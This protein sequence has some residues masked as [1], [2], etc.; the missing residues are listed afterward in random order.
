LNGWLAGEFDRV[1][2]ASFWDY[3]L[4]FV[5]IGAFSELALSIAGYDIRGIKKKEFVGIVRWILGSALVIGLIFLGVFIG[6]SLGASPLSIVL[7][8]TIFFTVTASTDT[9]SALSRTWFDGLVSN[10]ILVSVLIT[11]GFW[12][13]LLLIVAYYPITVI[14]MIL[15]RKAGQFSYGNGD[16]RR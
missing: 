7:A 16:R 12:I 13:G 15:K 11:L 3:F 10:F 2:S 5:A 6:N 1:V 9:M 8:M 4:V 14:P